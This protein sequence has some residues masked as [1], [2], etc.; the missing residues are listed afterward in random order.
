MHPR[1]KNTHT[2]QPQ[3]LSFHAVIF[4]QVLRRQRLQDHKEPV[5]SC[6]TTS[7]TVGV[8][9]PGAYDCYNLWQ[10]QC[11]LCQETNRGTVRNSISQQTNLFYKAANSLLCLKFCTKLFGASMTYGSSCPSSSSQTN[12]TCSL[13]YMRKRSGSHLSTW[14]IIT[15]H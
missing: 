10:D 12:P 15:S 2:S 6:S 3:I 14:R 11:F 4:W 13:P 7:C 1:D 9:L 8:F 5:L